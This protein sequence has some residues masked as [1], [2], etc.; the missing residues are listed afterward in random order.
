[1]VAT[2]LPLAAAC[3]GSPGAIS[4][5]PRATTAVRGVGCI[6]MTVTSADRSAAFFTR[7]LDFTKK[8]DTVVDE[9]K[10]RRVRVDLGTECVELDEPLAGVRRAMPADSR[11]NDLWFQHVA[12]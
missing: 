6:G 9:A 7:V 8:S 10:V 4:S 12:I 1:V 2:L 3:S 11:S 5:P